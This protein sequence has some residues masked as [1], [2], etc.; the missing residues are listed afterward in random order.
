MEKIGRYAILEKLKSNQYGEIYLAKD[1]RIGRQVIIKT[2]SFSRF[3]KKH[4]I[5][6]HRKQ[7]MREVKLAGKLLHPNILTV[8]DF[9]QLKNGF[10]ITMEYME[11][12][13]LETYL[14]THGTLSLNAVLI[15]SEQIARALQN[16]H[17]KGVVHQN[18]NPSS[19]LLNAEGQIKVTDF[20]IYRY[21]APEHVTS[22]GKTIGTPSYMAPEQ[23][24]GKAVDGR[25][26]LFSLGALMYQLVVGGKPF[27]GKSVSGIFHKILNDEPDK[28]QP[29]GRAIPHE[30]QGIITKALKKDP[31]ERYQSAEDMA[32]DIEGAKTLIELMEEPTSFMDVDSERM[33][34]YDSQQIRDVKRSIQGAAKKDTGKNGKEKKISP[35]F[36]PSQQV[37]G[38]ANDAATAQTRL[39]QGPFRDPV[40][41][42]DE[43]LQPP[44]GALIIEDEPP[45]GQ[46]RRTRR[47]EVGLMFGFVIV[48]LLFAI[49]VIYLFWGDVSFVLRFLQ[50]ERYESAQI[51]YSSNASDDNLSIPHD[52]EGLFGQSGNCAITI[53]SQPQGADIVIDGVVIGKTPYSNTEVL[54]GIYFMEIRHGGY[55]E[56]QE[57]IT[58]IPGTALQKAVTLV[59]RT[60]LV[61]SSNPQQ[62]I[63]SIDGNEYDKTPVEISSLTYG[64][65]DLLI[66][67][68]GYAPHREKFQ[69]SEADPQRSIDVQLMKNEYGSVRVDVEPETVTII[70]SEKRKGPTVFKNVPVGKQSV[71][72]SHRG[73]RNKTISVTVN[74]GKEAFVKHYFLPPGRLRI[75]AQPFGTAYLD[76]KMVGVTPVLLTDVPV[77]P[78]QIKVT[79]EGFQTARKQVIVR[80]G[81][82]D[83]VFIILEPDT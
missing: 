78:H 40:K 80:P 65:Y 46:V 57:E 31:D 22:A 73:Q 10:Y 21:A 7:Y 33:F 2:L 44:D 67:K 12:I 5:D 74:K 56:Y 70:Q 39:L 77:G 19:I 58:I 41:K 69:L 11:G 50:K 52:R 32:R 3:T 26:D 4:K 42:V 35:S 29:A 45:K 37:K 61:V 38:K 49:T 30:I 9:G 83:K 48:S 68:E 36:S 81:L 43:G 76:G 63:V 60:L 23:I 55:A 59:P 66:S 72:F 8:Y 47:N 75:S 82:E 20:G 53:D 64:T 79:K 16:A 25:T 27:S 18:I 54:E 51:P 15:I 62:A 17:A 34:Q 24:L 6:Y 14:Q 13:D 28:I 1:E 71:T